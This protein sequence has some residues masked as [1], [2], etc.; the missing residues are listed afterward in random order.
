MVLL[1]RK[2]FNQLLNSLFQCNLSKY[3][4]SGVEAATSSCF[5]QCHTHSPGCALLWGILASCGECR[6]PSPL[7]VVFPRSGETRGAVCLSLSW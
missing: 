3:L 5:V 6:C 1:W 2:S 4:T 7:L